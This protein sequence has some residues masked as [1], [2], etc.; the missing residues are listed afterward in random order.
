MMKAVNGIMTILVCL[1]I[2]LYLQ[3]KILV[4]VEATELMWFLFY[5]YI[6]AIIITAMI[7]V[8]LGEE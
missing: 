6:P 1:P 5:V 3:Y 7:R 4:L 8:A 2:W